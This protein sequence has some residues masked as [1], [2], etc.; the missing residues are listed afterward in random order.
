MR[1]KICGVTQRSDIDLLASLPVDL[2]GLWHGVHGGH[3]DVSL[4]EFAQLAATARAAKRLQPVLVTFLNDAAAL[5]EVVLRSQVRWI[6]LHGY[7]MPSLVLA[8]KDSLSPD[9]VRIIKV[10]HVRGRH[11]PERSLIRAYE[12]AG[13]DVFL[14]DTATEDGRV[15]STGRSLDAGAV[16]SLAERLTRPF[17]LAGGVSSQNWAAYRPLIRHHH[18]LGIDVDTNARGPDGKLRPERINAIS[19]AWNA[20]ASEGG[21]HVEQLR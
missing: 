16:S 2:V 1:I 6:Q 8:L 15:G 4:A 5:R 7:Q 12:Q 17:F 10:L 21:D 11:C 18:F 19:Q 20:C 13:V 14:F 9:G 3:A